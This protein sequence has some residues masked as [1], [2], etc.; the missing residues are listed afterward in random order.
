MGQVDLHVH[1]SVSDG[2]YT[3]EEIVKK[4]A[5]LG[6]KYLSIC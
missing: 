6:L 2:K 5:N 4:A 1:T 3:P